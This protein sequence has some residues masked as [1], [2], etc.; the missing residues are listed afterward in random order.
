[1]RL[2]VAIE[3]PQNLKSLLSQVQADLKTAVPDDWKITWVTPE[4]M[5]LTVQFIGGVEKQRLNEIIMS[6]QR[7]TFGV[8]PFEL[9]LSPLNFFPAVRPRVILVEAGGQLDIYQK[10]QNRVRQELEATDCQ[11]VS[12]TAPHVTLG[13]IKKLEGELPKEKWIRLAEK[14]LKDASEFVVDRVSLIQSTPTSE[15]SI[16]RTLIS[17]ALKNKSNLY[18]LVGKANPTPKI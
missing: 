11:L 18:K 6:L 12:K 5:H 8:A 3:L 7:A 2:F 10:L 17:L 9:D 13:R 15:G 1:M 16:Y 4:K 14:H